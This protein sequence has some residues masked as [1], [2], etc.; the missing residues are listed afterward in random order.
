MQTFMT[1]FILFMIYSFFGWLMEVIVTYPK[2]KK[3]VN[4]GF[5]IGPYC[6]IYGFGSTMIILLLKRYYDDILVLFVMAAVVCS[7]LEYMT[8]YFMEKIFKARWW[9]YS[10]LPFNINGRICLQNSFT[11]GILGI[12]LVHFI[13]PF[14]YNLVSL[15]PDIAMYIIFVLLSL[16]YVFDN[17]ISF[18]I[19][20]NIK[21]LVSKVKMDGTEEIT[22]K[23][24]DMLL[25][26]SHLF[27]R[28][29]RTFPDFRV[30]VKNGITAIKKHI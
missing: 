27:S 17:I 26:K 13:N 18:K 6:P 29:V 3:F 22:K 15:L 21:N 8:S 14:L 10:H 20:F 5:L 11:F 9:D 1:Y 28:V 7:I 30:I 19:M 16:I 12:I 25:S 4:R 2:A 23:V 24:K